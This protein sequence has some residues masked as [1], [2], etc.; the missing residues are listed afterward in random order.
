MHRVGVL[1]NA[2]SPLLA[3]RPEIIGRLERVVARQGLVVATDSAADVPRAARRF[4][5][6]GTDTVCI[7]GGDGTTAHALTALVDAYDA[8]A[9]PAIGLIRGGTINTTASYLG[10]KG[11]PVKLLQAIVSGRYCVRWLSTLEVNGLH[12]FT[13]GAGL[14]GRFYEEYDRRGER[15]RLRVARQVAAF[16]LA[17]LLGT[18]R[19]RGLTRPEPA[20]LRVDGEL[21]PLSRLSAVVASCLEYHGYLMRP[22]Y[23][24]SSRPGCFQ[25]V[26]TSMS[27][28]MLRRQCHRLILGSPLRGP[29]HHD[30]MAKEARIVFEKPAVWTL[31][32]EVFHSREI[33]LSIGAR[34]RM[35]VG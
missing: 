35:V 23:R 17:V 13:F 29:D 18:R 6:D 27:A 25:L 30:A 12:G 33:A 20:A 34:L 31:D 15:G 4:R 24:G 21:V 10:I 22:T 28:R 7:L 19:G 5:Q 11:D 3:R 16:V 8:D 9:L 26:A 2:Q 32:G 1:V 14:V